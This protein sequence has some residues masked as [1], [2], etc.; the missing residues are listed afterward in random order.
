MSD[1]IG[2]IEFHKQLDRAVAEWITESKP[3]IENTRLPSQTT[4]IQFMEY[5]F[6]KAMGEK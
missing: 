4:L 6:E 1:W 3:G 2:W 5:S